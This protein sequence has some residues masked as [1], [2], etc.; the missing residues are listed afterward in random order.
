L[1]ERKYTW[2]AIKKDKK[3]KRQLKKLGAIADSKKFIE[4]CQKIKELTGSGMSTKLPSERKSKPSKSF[5]FTETINSQFVSAKDA[6]MQRRAAREA[7][8]AEEK[9]K[10]AAKKASASGTAQAP[11]MI[12]DGTPDPAVQSS[13][14]TPSPSASPTKTT[15]KQSASHTISKPSVNTSIAGPQAKKPSLKDLYHYYLD[16]T[17]FEYKVTVARSNFSRNQITRYQISILESHTRPHTYCTYVQY[18]P[19]IGPAPEATSYTSDANMRSP[20]LAFLH[21]GRT[22]QSKPALTI[23]SDAQPHIS[24]AEATRLRALITPPAD[25]PIHPAEQARLHSLVTSPTP[26]P[27]TPYKTLICPMNSAFP[28]AWRAFRHVFRDLTLLSWEERFDPSKA[29]QTARAKTLNIEP[30]T[31]SRPS[32]SMPIGLSVQEAGMYQADR[33]DI[34]V[35]KGDAE[36]GYIRNAYGLPGIN[37]PL[38]TTGVVG[39]RI[40][41]EHS[42]V[43]KAEREKR[44]KEEE[45]DRREKERLKEE[46]RKVYRGPLFNGPMGRARVE[47][48]RDRQVV[49]REE[50]A[51]VWTKL[52][53]NR[54][55]MYSRDRD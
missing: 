26:S 24:Q 8:E 25:L 52:K 3:K 19:P 28:P 4:G 6:L 36:D 21:K 16:S 7:A 13:M 43:R 32:Q 41:R 42:E 55:I 30:Y 46:K 47:E 11:I 50:G 15:W 10:K 2:E 39:S 12:D 38:G 20:L 37:E 51:V 34:M 48:V 35:I 33:C 31:Y 54:R 22:E 17:G 9:A 1:A 44:E 5:F 29:I 18:T 49:K 45:R 23:T 53:V 27:T 40:W 14:P